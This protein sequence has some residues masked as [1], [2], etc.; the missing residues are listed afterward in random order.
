MGEFERQER[1]EREKQARA[2][3]AQ[4]KHTEPVPV[5]GEPVRVSEHKINIS[6][7][8]CNNNFFFYSQVPV[9]A[10]VISSRSWEIFRL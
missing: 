4:E 2:M 1:R 9:I 3:M 7:A 8:V 5:F 10:T 6:F